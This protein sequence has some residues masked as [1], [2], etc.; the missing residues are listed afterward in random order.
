MSW[1]YQP[2]KRGRQSADELVEKETKP[3]K[4]ICIYEDDETITTWKFD[5][6]KF[7]KGP[8]E[9]D[10]KYKAGAEKAIKAR[11]KEAKQIKKTERQMK[12]IQANGNNANK[13]GHYIELLDRTHVIMEMIDT[14]L[15]NHPLA[16]QDEEI[17][18]QLEYA[19]G[20]LYDAY[21]LIGGKIK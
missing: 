1:K 19:L 12:K 14:H 16:T 15:V 4:F 8:I 9:V 3:T 18:H 13:K 21:Q 5:L 17:K 7:D 20:Q 2:K 10:I 11:V 6:K